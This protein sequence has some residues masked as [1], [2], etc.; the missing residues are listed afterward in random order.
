M[1]T[2]D[3][4]GY[5]VGKW[6]RG[7]QGRGKGEE[8]GWEGDARGGRQGPAADLLTQRASHETHELSLT[9]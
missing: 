5:D 4:G 7:G 2:A 8:E 1:P 6:G 9:G 3:L